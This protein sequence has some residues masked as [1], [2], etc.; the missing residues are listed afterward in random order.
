MSENTG[1][2][3]LSG[4]SQKWYEGITR[5]QWLVLT[6]A[7]PGRTAPSSEGRRSGF[8]LTIGAPCTEF[9][10]ATLATRCCQS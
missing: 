9:H 7:S 2:T 3:E 5:Y 6:I 10:P 1:K 4:S 8:D